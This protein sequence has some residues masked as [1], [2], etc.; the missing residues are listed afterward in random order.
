MREAR[1]ALDEVEGLREKVG[2]FVDGELAFVGLFELTVSCFDEDAKND[3]DE[4][5]AL[6][7]PAN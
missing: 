1:D 7:T 3:D 2:R 5:G 4:E 6:S